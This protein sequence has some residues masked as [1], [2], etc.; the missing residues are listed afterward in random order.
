[1]VIKS[2]VICL[3]IFRCLNAHA[4]SFRPFKDY[5]NGN[6]SNEIITEIS[7]FDPLKII[8]GL[9]KIY[10]TDAVNNKFE[11]LNRLKKLLNRLA[12]EMENDELLDFVENMQTKVND[13]LEFLEK[14]KSSIFGV[15]TFQYNSWQ[16][17]F[18][19]RDLDSNDE[20]RKNGLNRGPCFGGGLEYG[21]SFYRISF[22]LCVGFLA[23]FTNTDSE[24]GV[25]TTYFKS[26]MGYSYFLG[27]RSRIGA[28]I[29]LLYRS[30]DFEVPARSELNGT[31]YFNIGGSLDYYFKLFNNLYF[32]SSIG[33]YVSSGTLSW[34]N[35]I[36]LV[37]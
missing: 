24:S 26:R 10:S 36:N 34:N 25:E 21:N 32:F 19:L 28:N 4:F 18:T 9:K 37:F 2:I 7:K 6:D 23:V 30:S 20:S 33:G 16:D 13:R 12:N 17:H 3:F 27:D 29:N 35:G 14:S 31:T 8:A 15:V 22:D 5:L 11:K 1:M